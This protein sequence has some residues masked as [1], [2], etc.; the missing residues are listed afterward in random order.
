MLKNIRFQ[1]AV[2][3]LGI[4]S[5]SLAL[6]LPSFAAE[7]KVGTVDMQE[8]LKSVSAG[9][10]AKAQLEKEFN[11]KKKELDTEQAAIKK[12]GEE[13]EKQTLLLSDEA[14][15]KKQA[16][17]QKR[18]MKFQEQTARAQ[19]EIQQKQNDLTQPIVEK[20]K[21]TIDELA[22]KRAYTVVLEKS[23]NSVLYSLPKDDLTNDVIAAYEKSSS[24]KG[25]SK[26]DDS[27]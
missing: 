4:A 22:E 23:G 20:L 21:K 6:G 18:V 25:K 2:K 27:E 24:G 13:Y 19:A 15:A 17:L 7:T 14:R 5:V 1:S 12:M 8:A 9:K 10:K 11:A 3:S 16:E 26:V